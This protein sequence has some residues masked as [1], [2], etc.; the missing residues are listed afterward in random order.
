MNA[1]ARDACF[2]DVFPPQGACALFEPRGGVCRRGRTSGHAHAPRPVALVC[3]RCAPKNPQVPVGSA[4]A[5]MADVLE[6]PKE[7]VMRAQSRSVRVS[8]SNVFQ[9]MEKIRR[10]VRERHER[11]QAPSAQAAHARSAIQQFMALRRPAD[12]SGF[13]DDGV[14]G[15]ADVI[16][17]LRKQDGSAGVNCNGFI[18]MK[19][20]REVRSLAPLGPC[21]LAVA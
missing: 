20:C 19:R 17:A 11:E 4:M 14:Q 5:D 15:P 6:K 18:R 7:T 21:S 10:N 9:Q 2:C 16:A 12:D 3:H 13:E 8:L 1:A